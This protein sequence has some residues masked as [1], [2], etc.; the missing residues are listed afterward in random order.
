MT[1]PPSAASSTDHK[2][3]IRETT[4]AITYNFTGMVVGLEVAEEPQEEQHSGLRH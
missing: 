2:L 3:W 4:R 1:P